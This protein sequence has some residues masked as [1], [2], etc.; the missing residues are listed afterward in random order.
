MA[1]TNSGSLIHNTTCSI[2]LLVQRQGNI[3]VNIHIPVDGVINHN[4]RY[5]L[6]SVKLLENQRLKE[7]LSGNESI[8]VET[9]TKSVFLF[10][11]RHHVTEFTELL[12]LTSV[13]HNLHI[14]E[15]L[16]LTTYD[17]TKNT[18]ENSNKSQ[19]LG[20]NSMINISLQTESSPSPH[21][22]L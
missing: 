6:K 9:A 18:K 16:L 2:V 1:A 7:I 20:G 19:T 15:L 8:T 21:S 13:K 12:P 11:C 22:M 14:P 3:E 4:F 17:Q 10:Y 5:R